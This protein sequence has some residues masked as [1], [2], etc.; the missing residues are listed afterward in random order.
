M[1]PAMAERSR[2][3]LVVIPSYNGRALLETCLASV[4]RHLPPGLPVEVVVADDGSTDGTAG[5]LAGNP[6]TLRQK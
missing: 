3:H 5:W 1:P 4:A 2:T 6:L